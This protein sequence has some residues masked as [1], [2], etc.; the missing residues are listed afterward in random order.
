[1]SQTRDALVR[2]REQKKDIF[3]TAHGAYPPEVRQGAYIGAGLT[4][5]AEAFLAVAADV[6]TLLE[7]DAKR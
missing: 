1:M 3:K 6:L 4:A 7:E 5:I 2:T